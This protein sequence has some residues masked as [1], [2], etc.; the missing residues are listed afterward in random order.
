MKTFEAIIEDPNGNV[1]GAVTSGGVVTVPEPFPR[2]ELAS[3]ARALAESFGITIPAI[4][5]AQL[6]PE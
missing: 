5:D 1:I 4:Q 6:P 2:S 3:R